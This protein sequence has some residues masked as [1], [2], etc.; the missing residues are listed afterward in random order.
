MKIQTHGAEEI[1]AEVGADRVVAPSGF[2]P[3]PAETLDPSG[4]VRPHEL[5]IAVERLCLDSTS[6][7]QIAAS[8]GGDAGAMAA[9]VEEIVA[10]RGK[11]HNPV[12]DSGGIL[13]GT[14]S[15]VGAEFPDAP[16]IGTPT[17]TLA[18]LTLTPLRLDEVT[19]LDP[20]SPQVGV[21][22]TAYICGRAAWTE[23]PSFLSA[24]KALEVFDVCA[25]ASHTRDLVPVDGSVCVLGAG[26]AGKLALAA[27]RDASLSSMLTV[28]DVDSDAVA[29]ALSHGLADIGV[30]TDL[31]DP[32]G[33]L[34]AMQAAGV[35]PADL[36]VV[37]V[38]ATGCEAAAI[39]ATAPAGRI[40]FFSMATSF[41]TAAL[42]SD[43]LSSDA[44]M[45]IG[46]GFSPDRGTYALD[47]VRRNRGLREAMGIELGAAA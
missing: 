12:T 17:V 18:S 25:A 35:P 20:A 14:V 23:L 31:R 46:S 24:E 38:N 34:A 36:T 15:A 13:M 21:R 42:T 6:H 11:M 26:H 45:V 41:G 2:L 22:G 40:L 39:L 33:A 5:E 16:E 8:A 32:L 3:Q 7:R 37:V 43:G 19:H 44:R 4:P 27:A 10:E 9:R 28:V 29:H 1:A 30:T 47:L